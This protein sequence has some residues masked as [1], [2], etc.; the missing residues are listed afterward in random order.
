MRKN[1]TSIFGLLKRKAGNLGL[2]VTCLAGLP[3]AFHAQTYTLTSCGQTGP[4]LPTQTQANSTYAATNVNGLVTVTAGI[5][6]FTVPA[7]GPYRI[8]A[9]GGQGGYNGGNGAY[10]SGDYTLTAGTILKVLVG[11]QGTSANNGSNGSGGG[12]GGSFVT[13]TANVPYVVA[14]GGGGNGD[15]YNGLGN[16]TPCCRNGMEA[17]LTTSGNGYAP[18][19]TGG[20]PGGGG[21]TGGSGGTCSGSAGGGAGFTGNGSQCSSGS[22]AQA[23]VNGGAAGLNNN[24]AGDGGFG[25]GGGCYNSGTGERGGG[26]G[27]YS[28]GGGGA[29]FSGYDAA[30]GG[31]GSFISANAVNPTASLVTSTGDGKVLITLL[32]DVHINALTASNSTNAAICAGQSVT[33]TTNAASNFSWSTGATTQSIVVTPGTS[34]NYTVSGTSSLSCNAGG[35][36]SVTV[37]P[38]LPNL[39]VNTSTPNTCLGNT[40]SIG[41]SGALTYTFSSSI[42]NSVAFTP[43]NTGVNNYTITGGNGCGTTTTIIP[44]TIAQLPLSVVPTTTLVCANTSATL[45][46]SGANSYTWNPGNSNFSNYVIFPSANTIYTVTGKTGSCTGV[47]T[48]AINTVANPTLSIS[49]TNSVV[50]SGDAVNLSVNG[51]A[52]SYTWTP[53]GQVGTSTTD[54]PT[55]VTLYQV[56]GVNS[57]NCS[58]VAQQVVIVNPLPALSAGVSVPLVCPG[59]TSTLSA[60]GASTY[61]W[62]GGVTSSNASVVVNPQTTTNYTVTGTSSLACSASTVVVVNVFAPSITVSSNTTICT[63][64]SAIIGAGAADSWLWSNGATSQNIAVSGS[65]TA[66]FTVTAMVNNLNGLSCPATAS[67]QVSIFT[68]PV[69]TATTNLDVICLGNFAV[70]SASGAGA[71]GT[72]TWTGGAHPAFAATNTV[73]PISNLTYTVLGTDANG[74][75]GM[76]TIQ[77]VVSPCTGIASISANNINVSIYP[78][79][80]NGEFTISTDQVITLQITNELGQQVKVVNLNKNATEAKVSNLAN[81]IYFITGKN[82]NG[83]VKQK[84]VIAK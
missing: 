25:G 5:Q 56:V 32:C 83:S 72:Y 69:I 16:S 63:G 59:G 36:L 30:G 42:S 33:L 74:C 10:V 50:C 19:T 44:I 13:S 62:T 20:S 28:G 23:F 11:Q 75:I 66:V 81:G 79:P 80:S 12:G 6:Y 3:T 82:E 2:V 73:A 14:G 64:Q 27:G 65:Q 55:G 21:G 46:V 76:A 78:N 67:V 38:G 35:A 4:S 54:H 45:N 41:V 53:T 8:A 48:I 49:L 57:N 84:I 39:T 7:T 77:Q 43:T 31:G 58:S 9:I 47:S 22:S 24:L 70:L 34:T 61:A 29:A 51:N 68:P 40:V 60:S 1:Y 18:S 17:S 52:S 37:S 26:G 71:N 15:G